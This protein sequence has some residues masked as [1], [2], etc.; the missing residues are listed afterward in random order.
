MRRRHPGFTL[1]ELMIVVAIIGILSTVA[2]PSFSRM[3]L[4]SKM[5]ERSLMVASLDHAIDDYYARDASYPESCGQG[6]SFLSLWDNPGWPP[7]PYKRKLIIT[8]RGDDWSQLSLKIEGDLY[9]DYWGFASATGGSRWIQIAA[10]SDLEG[11]GRTC[12]YMH[13]RQYLGTVK[14]GDS[15]WD[16]N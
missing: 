9:Y 1:I 10:I 7:A 14:T 13:W 2:I 3:Q 4:R 12:T 11:D 15:V 16:E 5:A 8:P 6:C